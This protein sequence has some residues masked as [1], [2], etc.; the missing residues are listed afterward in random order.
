MKNI[1][2][3]S[4]NLDEIKHKI[5]ECGD[6]NISMATTIPSRIIPYIME[7][8]STDAVIGV[9]SAENTESL[10][11]ALFEVR[12]NFPNVRVGLVASSLDMSSSENQQ[13]VRIIEGAG[14]S[15]LLSDSIE[16]LNSFLNGN[17]SNADDALIVENK[18]P[19][20]IIVITSAKAGSGKSF[21]STNLATILAMYG[22]GK[23]NGKGAKPTVLLVEGDLQTLSVGTLM[24]VANTEHNL[25]NALKQIATIVDANGNV[26][27]TAEQQYNVRHFIEECC[28]LA[29]K[30]INNLAT[31]VSAEFSLEERE[32]VSP[33]HYFY[34]L[35]VLSEL[36]DIVIVDSNS[37][38]EHKTTGPV[39]Q[40]ARDIYMVVT[41]DY[42]GVRVASKIRAE[43]DLLGCGDKIHFVLNKCLTKQQQ[44][45]SSE[46]SDFNP[47]EYFDKKKIVAKIPFIDQVIQYNSIYSRSPLVMS[48]KPETLMARMAFT[49]L[50]ANIWPMN[51]YASLK[52]EIASLKAARQKGGR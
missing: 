38:I 4:Q 28:L 11:D 40:V 21:V 33:Y 32:T 37:A 42:D 9:L 50:A 34:L 41:A 47:E 30:K 15:V 22:R 16:E 35:N 27:G 26:I 46:K 49:K 24:G 45:R 43:Y 14:I 5:S 10:P 25:K 36:F 31:I 12:R 6:V 17:H 39:L 13:A 1:V 7:N 48:K 52:K 20:N 51:N 3:V 8:G 23:Q 44:A 18:V 2:V 19:D 29:N